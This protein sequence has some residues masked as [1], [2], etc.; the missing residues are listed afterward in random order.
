MGYFYDLESDI[1]IYMKILITGISGSGKST[2]IT[3]LAQKGHQTIDLDTSNTCIWV[4]K[5]TGEEAFYQE[6]AGPLWIEEHRWQVVPHKL[7]SLMS[8]FSEEKDIYVSGKVAR[9]QLNEMVE[10]FDVIYLLKPHNTIIDERL[11]TRTSNVNNFAKTKEEIE[12]ITKNRDKFE[13]ACLEAGAISLENQGSLEEVISI[14][15]THR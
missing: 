3:E 2:I 12:V 9:K 8:S 11:S 7:V 4:N 15:T 1:M 14:L 10:I 5:K 6:G 13:K